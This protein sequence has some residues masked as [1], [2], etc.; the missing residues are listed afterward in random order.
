MPKGSPPKKAM[1]DL[2]VDS[3]L[4]G[5]RFYGLLEEAVN[6]LDVPVDMI[7]KSQ[8]NENSA[9]YKEIMNTGVSIYGA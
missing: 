6:A 8:V 3:G 1:F 2:F 9:V 7:G 5:L 4:R